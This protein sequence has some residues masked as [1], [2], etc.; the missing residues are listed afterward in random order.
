[1]I[2]TLNDQKEI[3]ESLKIL[4]K[5]KG[6]K[7]SPE[8]INVETVQEALALLERHGK[9]GVLFSGFIAD[10]AD[11]IFDSTDFYKK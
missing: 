6:T 3:M 8:Y 11:K 5:L 10:S 7:V 9:D 4:G 2:T 1:M